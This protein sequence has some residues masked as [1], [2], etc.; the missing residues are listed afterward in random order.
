MGSDLHPP[1]TSGNYTKRFRFM[2]KYLFGTVL[3]S[4]LSIM[5]L[6]ANQLEI[7]Q[8]KHRAVQALKNID[9][10][11]DVIGVLKNKGSTNLLSL[12]ELDLFREV[13]W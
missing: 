9:Q 8:S 13:Q 11:Y 1:T 2:R 12:N 4:L 5:L 3:L 7:I 6:V 10:Q